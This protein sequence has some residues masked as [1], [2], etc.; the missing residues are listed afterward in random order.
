MPYI[1]EVA[2]DIKGQ[3]NAK[4]YRHVIN[5]LDSINNAG[6]EKRREEQIEYLWDIEAQILEKYENY[7]F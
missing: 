6:C 5:L 7:L 3:E 4:F 2:S 1:E